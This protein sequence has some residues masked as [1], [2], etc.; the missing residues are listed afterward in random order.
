MVGWTAGFGLEVALND[1]VSLALEY[2][3][4]DYG[5]ETFH[6]SGDDSSNGP[7]FPGAT[8]VDFM[9]DQVTVKMNILLNHIFGNGGGSVAGKTPATNNVAA[10]SPF[11]RSDESM[12]VG[13]TKAK[14]ASKWSAKDKEVAPVVEEF[15][16]TGF[17]IGANVGGAWVDYDFH[18]FDAEVDTGELFFENASG[19][20]LPPVQNSVEAPQG[21]GIGFSVF[22]PFQVHSNDRGS[23]DTIIGG[24]QFGYQHQF[25]IIGCSV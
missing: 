9:N 23:D 20:L 6:F 19:I 17:Y 7:I 13:Y 18:H 10:K 1:A 22:A 8:N 4:N 24:G 16:W 11:G 15:N 2:R 5:D 12:Q 14:D 21:P 3:H 25:G